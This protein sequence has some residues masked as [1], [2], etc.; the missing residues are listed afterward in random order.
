[1]T[2]EAA[3]PLPTLADITA[4]G[5]RLAAVA[6]RTPL[7]HSP[8][9]SAHTGVPVY[10]K[11]ECWQRTRAFKMRGAYNAIASLSQDTRDTGLVTASAGNHGQAV[12]LSASLLGARATVFVPAD[13]PDV[14]KAR[15]RAFGAELNDAA[16]TYD[17]AERDAADFA[18]ATHQYFVHPFSDPAVVAGQGTIA[19][20]I[21]DDLP[22]VQSVIVPVGGGGLATGIGLTLRALSSSTTLFGVQSSETRAMYDAFAAGGIVDSPITPTIADGLAGCTDHIAYTWLRSL[23][24]TIHLAPE[25]SLAGAIRSL[26]TTSGIVA[27]GAGAVGVAALITGVI[28]PR[29]PTAVVITGG[30]IDPSRLAA[31]LST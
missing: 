18:R 6:T 11:L 17:D 28:Q 10:L 16:A 8:W 30:N 12:A 1:M 5:R 3:A 24:D 19:L 13:A 7:E 20:E 21:I 14:K 9:L 26:F 22:S 23:I 15:I 31:I 27:E 25:E 2:P 4:A 29:G